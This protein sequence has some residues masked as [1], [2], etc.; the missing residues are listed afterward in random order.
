MSVDDPLSRAFE[1]VLT[2]LILAGVGWWLDGLLDV[3]PFLTIGLA[4]FGLIGVTV[5]MWYEYDARMSRME[6]DLAAR[7]SGTP[8]DGAGE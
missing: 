7:R 5:R 1:L 6:A 2:P 4:V 3:R 8:T